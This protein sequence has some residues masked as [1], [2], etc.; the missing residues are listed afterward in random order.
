MRGLA[1]LP[2]PQTFPFRE[3][4]Q[5]QGLPVSFFLSCVAK[6]VMRASGAC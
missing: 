3:V 5:G 6:E 1:T 2:G 4:T